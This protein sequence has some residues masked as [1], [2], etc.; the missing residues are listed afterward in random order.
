[1]ARVLIAEDLDEFDLLIQQY[2]N[3]IADPQLTVEKLKQQLK[4]SMEKD[5]R[6][7]LGAYDQDN[8]ALGL[9]IHNPNF[10]RSS[11]IF[12]NSDFLVEKDLFD[13]MF[14][15]FSGISP[16]IILDSGYP[17]PWIS[18]EFSEYAISLGFKKH[19]RRFMILERLESMV[20]HDL[21]EGFHF[22][23]FSELEIEDVT[24][25]VFQSVDGSTDQDLFPYVYGSFDTTLRFHKRVIAG[26]FGIHK[27]SF[28]WI[29]KRGDDCIG[30]CFITTSGEYTGHLMH[31]AILPDFRQRGLGKNLLLHSLHNLFVVEPNLKKVDL[32]V[33]LDNP[34]RHLYKSIGFKRVNDMSTFVWKKQNQ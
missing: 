29:L 8:K 26:D 3:H 14:G 27:P 6:Y 30:A 23:P 1:M 24:K 34:A 22:T 10:N 28:S 4:Q 7:V 18:S 32:A 13:K 11:L 5:S 16:T 31:L 19:D 33:T 2:I 12:A 25:M 9:L 21:P 20:Y 15:E 17:K